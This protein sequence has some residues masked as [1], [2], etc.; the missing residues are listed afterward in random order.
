MPRVLSAAVHTPV[1]A[2]LAVLHLACGASD[3]PATAQ[4]PS[5][6]SLWLQSHAVRLS[7]VDPSASLDELEPL[8]QMVGDA[9]VVALGEAT[10][11]TKEFF[12]MKHRILRFLVERMGF[13]AFAIEASW[14]EA[15]R[16]DRYVRA[17]E[18]NPEVLLSGLYFWTWNTREVLDMIQ[19]M[20]QQNAAG[21]QV[22]FY[23]FDMQYPGM[24]I[25]NVL[26]FVRVVDSR[27]A[28]E[29][30]QHLACLSVHANDAR[31]QFPMPGYAAQPQA[32]RDA[33]L[34]D[35]SWVETALAERQVA[36]GARSS[37]ADWARAARSARVAVQY[38]QMRSGRVTRDAS[39]ADNAS[40][41]LDQLGPQGKI[42]L[43]AHNGH[44]WTGSGA[45]GHQLRQAFG[46]QLFV[47]GFDF[48]LG[49]FTGVRYSGSSYQGLGVLS[50]ERP[51]ASSY[52]EYF[53]AAE[54]PEFLLDLR[55]HDLQSADSRWLAGPRSFRSIGCCYDPGAAS[56][57]WSQA[58]LPDLFDAIV[59]FET[60]SP[61]ILLPFQYPAAF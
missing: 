1:L 26:Q 54:I 13:T 53:A 43:W 29:F 17:G 61:S 5:P 59:F 4:G 18:G 57:Y 31:G 19:W 41:L 46:R 28:A 2:A 12:Q 23:G 35:L 25:D 44:V 37:E 9:R 11:G 40:W 60:S 50:V 15:N 47:L 16:I 21:R 6:E 14:P 32:Y 49:N 7:H 20:R 52:E 10:H 22:G 3:G 45:M 56:S 39:M 33:C 36:Y 8:R 58:R 27:A 55:G 38:E 34:A 42:V 48:A 30:E 24:A 51:V